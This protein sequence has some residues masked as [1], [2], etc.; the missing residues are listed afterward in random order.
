MLRERLL[1][2][3]VM[4]ATCLVA[5]L[6]FAPSGAQAHAGHGHAVQPDAQVTAP[7]TEPPAHTQALNVLPILQ[8]DA[9]I[10]E[11]ADESALLVPAKSSGTPQTC[12]GGCCHSAGTG[13]CAVAFPASF[14]MFVP[15]IGRLMLVRAVIGGPGI[16]P[17][18]L[19]EPPR[20][21]V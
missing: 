11:A 17:G 8:E 19:P 9:T 20:F 1:S 5:A 18:A 13:C 12:P 10:G 16:T 15:A 7:I 6:I 2:R 21:L 4:A 3:L 14:E